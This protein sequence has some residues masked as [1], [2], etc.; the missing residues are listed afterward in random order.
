MMI[1]RLVHQYT[2]FRVCH[3][4]H[5]AQS[6]VILAQAPHM[7]L[8]FYSIHVF[9]LP[10]SACVTQKL[11]IESYN[12]FIVKVV[13]LFSSFISNTFL[14]KINTININSCC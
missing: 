3:N 6:F 2:L 10:N 13:Y 12:F 1:S 5:L 7:L 11:Q 14:S 9:K 8:I 4:C